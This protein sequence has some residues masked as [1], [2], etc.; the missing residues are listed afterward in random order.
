HTYQLADPVRRPSAVLDVPLP[1]EDQPEDRQRESH[2][3]VERASPGPTAPLRTVGRHRRA[4]PTECTP[5]PD[6]VGDEVRVREDPAD[7]KRRGA[8]QR[9]T[10]ERQDAQYSRKQASG[11]SGLQDDG[12]TGQPGSE[13]PDPVDLDV[14]RMAVSAV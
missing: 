10:E 5:H 12:S 1:T 2:E 8:T 4:L 14:V 3:A 9:M 7:A 6:P 13:R 11:N